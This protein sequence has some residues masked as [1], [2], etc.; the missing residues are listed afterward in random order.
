MAFRGWPVE[1][2]QFFEGLEADNSKAFWTA[3]KDVYDRGVWPSMEERVTGLAPEFGPGKLFFPYRDV[4]FGKDKT[5]YRTSVSAL[6]TADACLPTHGDH[7]DAG[8]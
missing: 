8:T 2:V 3:N 1:A 4:R 6:V 5:P 7:A